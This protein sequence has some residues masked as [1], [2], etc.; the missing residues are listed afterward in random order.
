M[1]HPSPLTI[2]FDSHRV[3]LKLADKP[4]SMSVSQYQTNKVIKTSMKNMRG[5]LGRC[6]KAPIDVVLMSGHG[7]EKDGL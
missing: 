4:N 2:P 3:F 1:L 7:G 5:G 6:R